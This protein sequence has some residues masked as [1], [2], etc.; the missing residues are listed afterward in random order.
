MTMLESQIKKGNSLS[1]IVNDFSIL[2][3]TVN[4]SGS[5]TANVTL[6]RALFQM[7][8]PVSGK[9]IFPSNIQGLPTWYT[10]R[11]NEN[12]FLARQEKNQIVVAMNATTFK[13]DVATLS[14]GGVLFYADDITLAVGRD[15]IIIYPMAINQLAKASNVP[16]RLVNYIKN[17]VYVGILAEMLGIDLEKIYKALELHF[18]GKKTAVESNYQT[19]VQAANWAKENLTKSD[20]Y[21]VM[22]SN[23]TDGWIITEGNKAGAMGAVFGGVQFCA[24]Y[25]ITPATSLVERLDEYLPVFRRDPETGKDNFAVVQ[26][27]DELSAVGMAIGAGWGGLRSMTSTS[28]PG[29]SL[30]AEYIGLAYFSEIPV[31]IWDVQR[32]GPSTGMPTRTSQGDITFANFISHGDTQF[33]LL[34]PGN[35]SECYEFGWRAFDIAEKIQSPVLIMSDM[36]LGMNQWISPEF[37]Y[38]DKPVERGKILWEKDLEALLKERNGD[39]GRYLDIDGDGIPYRT[40]IGNQHPRSG[41][42]ARGTGHDEYARY[43]EAPEVWE[44]NSKRIV[45]KF[46]TILPDLPKAV[47]EEM[48]QAQFGIITIGSNE[49]A[50]CEAQTLLHEKGIN[51]DTLRIRSKPF[52]PEIEEF[53]TGHDHSY[54]VEANDE[55][56]L[57]QLL[58]LEYPHYADKLV[59]LSKNDGLPISAE[60]IVKGVL[61]QEEK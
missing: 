41:Y 48:D 10:I 22:P 9:N 53:I 18:E 38:P 42:F 60:M 12:G 30:M 13:D 17:M 20:P 11:V 1:S 26:A 54:V 23:K 8:I 49:L 27:E 7:G 34:F 44:R 28:G 3:A 56:Q 57:R 25:P 31:V 16:A 61:S 35:M 45:K 14:T 37:K 2:F 21:R 51:V 50:V 29:L 39:W 24:W 59:Q 55:G 36:D 32:M 43:T 19:V 58:I 52:G 5:A 6:M 4:G 47:L 46:I 33:V 15:D 40:L